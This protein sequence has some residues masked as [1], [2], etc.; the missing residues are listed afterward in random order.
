M[1]KVCFNVERPKRLDG[2]D[3]EL[4]PSLQGATLCQTLLRPSDD[5]RSRK[6]L[7]S[8]EARRVQLCEFLDSRRGGRERDESEADREWKVLVVPWQLGSVANRLFGVKGE[9]FC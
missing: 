6:K 5:S 2:L 8:T 4:T 1:G 9:V 3:D 7:L